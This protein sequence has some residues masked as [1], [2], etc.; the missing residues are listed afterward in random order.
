MLKEAAINNTY[1]TLGHN[2]RKIKVDP[3]KNKNL[4]QLEK[5]LDLCTRIFR[6]VSP[7]DKNYVGIDYYFKVKILL[8]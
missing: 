8:R 6:Q 5:K 2:R 3:K 7:R 1:G 4:H